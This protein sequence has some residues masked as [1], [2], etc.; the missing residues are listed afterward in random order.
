LIDPGGG[1]LGDR[2]RRLARAL[3]ELAGHVR[4]GV[5]R[6]VGEAAAG[7]VHASVR[8]ALGRLFPGAATALPGPQDNPTW[9]RRSDRGDSYGGSWR[10]P[11]SSWGAAEGRGHDRSDDRDYRRPDPWAA[12][13]EDDPAEEAEGWDEGRDWRAEET[14]PAAPRGQARPSP[15][16]PARPPFPMRRLLTALGL[17]L[18]VAAWAWRASAVGGAGLALLGLTSAAQAAAALAGLAAT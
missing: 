10:G 14:P 5:A 18:A 13:G 12:G 15:A 16:T 7:A 8:D 2:L 11:S 3:A 6:A 4:D 9:G 1:T 17:G